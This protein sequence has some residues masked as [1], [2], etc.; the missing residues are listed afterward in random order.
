MKPQ[1]GGFKA[2]KRPL[3]GREKEISWLVNLWNLDR[4]PLHDIAQTPLWI[5]EKQNNEAEIKARK[6]AEVQAEVDWLEQHVNLREPPAPDPVLSLMEM[7]DIPLTKENWISARWAAQKR[8]WTPRNFQK[9][10]PV[11]KNKKRS[12]L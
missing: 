11:F 5:Q 1:F 2:S 9:W 6:A 4:E 7:L 8:T 10:P 3:S 12:N